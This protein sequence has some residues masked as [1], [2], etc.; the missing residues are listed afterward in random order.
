MTAGDPSQLRIIS[1]GDLDGEVWGAAIQAGQPAIAFHTP[2]GGSA[3]AGDGAFSLTEES[4]GWR[5]GGDRFELLAVPVHDGGHGPEAG[6]ELCVVSGTLAGS[7][8]QCLGTITS[9]PGLKRGRLDSVRGLSGWFASDRG[10]ELLALRPAGGRGHEADQI[11]ATVF[12]PEGAIAVDDPRISTTFRAGELPSRASLELWIG[13]GEEQ[14]PRRAA[15]EANGE[16]SEANGDGVSLQVTPLRCHTGGLDGAG[17]YV[18][19]RF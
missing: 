6:S 19:A 5:L 16:P 18:L 2:D 14:Y 10:L 4:D 13:E 11:A 9:R 17:V 8:V 12:E 7:D 1:F 15:A 3:A